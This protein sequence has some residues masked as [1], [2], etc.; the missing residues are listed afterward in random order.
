VSTI[1]YKRAADFPNPES[2]IPQA[3][4]WIMAAS[5]P[6]YEWLLGSPELAQSAVSKWMHR[7]S[8]EIFIR[9]VRFVLCD[10]QIEGG[11]LGMSGQELKKARMADAEALWADADESRRA[12]LL[13]RMSSVS[14]LFPPVRD[15]DFYMSK[16]GLN[17]SARGRGRAWRIA[18]E[19]LRDVF[20]QGYPRLRL[21]VWADNEVAIRIYQALGFEL[22]HS[23]QSADGQLKYQSMVIAREKS[24]IKQAEL[25]TS[26]RVS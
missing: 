21:D 20:S 19:A 6:Y 15:D 10:S 5:Y 16:F 12:T 3:V 14:N 11:Y 1:T 26:N 18:K 2:T 7:P 25:E 9:R 17:P 22:I 4:P 8:S 23:A 24:E 13:Q